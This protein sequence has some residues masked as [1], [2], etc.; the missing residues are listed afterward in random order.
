MKTDKGVR[1]RDTDELRKAKRLEPL[2][3]S[4]KERHALY[5]S[6]DDE[7]D[8]LPRPK[9]ESALDYFDEE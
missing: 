1:T 7:D 6:M 9:R 8:D 5:S 3:K 2:H 4:G